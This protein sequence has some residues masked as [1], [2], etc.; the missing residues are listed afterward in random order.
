M[1]VTA[2]LG[3][4]DSG[5]DLSVETLLLSLL[6]NTAPTTNIEGNLLTFGVRVRL[7]ISVI[8]NKL[9]G[10]TLDSRPLKIIYLPLDLTSPSH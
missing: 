8:L 3:L 6:D 4:L 5:G 7:A 2:L 9:R 10:K 1:K